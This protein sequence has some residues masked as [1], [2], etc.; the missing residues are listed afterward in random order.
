MRIKILVLFC[1]T[2]LAERSG[3]DFAER[4]ESDAAAESVGDGGGRNGVGDDVHGCCGD[5]QQT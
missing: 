2:D 5:G 1:S 4:S 3:N